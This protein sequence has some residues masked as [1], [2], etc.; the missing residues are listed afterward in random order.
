MTVIAAFRDLAHE[1][2]YMVSD[3][4]TDGGIRYLEKTKIWEFKGGLHVGLAG[5][6]AA[7]TDAYVQLREMEKRRKKLTVW[8]VREA[9]RNTPATDAASAVAN[10]HRSV[11]AL[12]CKG[13]EMWVL[14]SEGA[15]VEVWE[16]VDAMAVGTGA[17]FVL[18]F[19]AAV[20]GG[21]DPWRG[22]KC[23]VLRAVELAGDTIPGVG[24]V[25]PLVEVT[26]GD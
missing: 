17:E 12:V 9:I 18:G 5:D 24:G 20:R 3:Q 2:T 1:I 11:E 14:D 15:A 6:V 23:A 7:I 4:A 25:S 21:D 16:G 13:P 8:H 10:S 26:H 22:T 19:M